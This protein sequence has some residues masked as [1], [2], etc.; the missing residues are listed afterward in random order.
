[1]NARQL[2]ILAG[3]NA[4]GHAYVSA[5]EAAE[6]PALRDAGLVRVW[7]TVGGFPAWGITQAGIDKLAEFEGRTVAY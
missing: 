7:D 6:I 2:T 5:T 4:V 3:L 1:M